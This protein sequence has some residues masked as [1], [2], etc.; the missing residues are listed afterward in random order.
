MVATT[1][2]VVSRYL[3][4]FEGAGAGAQLVDHG[5]WLRDS[6]QVDK[7][8]HQYAKVRGYLPIVF[9]ATKGPL[10]N[11]NTAQL[12][13]QIP[14]GTVLPVGVFH[15]SRRVRLSFVQQLFAPQ[16]GI[17]N[18]LVAESGSQAAAF[19]V[20]PDAHVA[21]TAREARFREVLNLRCPDGTWA[22]VYWR[23]TGPR[24]T[25]GGTHT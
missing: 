4:A 20:V 22:T 14:F 7:F 9:F 16:Y 11:T 19:T 1:S 17:P 18:F 24:I 12:E 25:L 8:M 2:S 21:R 10:F 3:S 6:W 5:S 13:N 15:N 23:A